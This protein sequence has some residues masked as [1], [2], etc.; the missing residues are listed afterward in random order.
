MALALT[1]RWLL[2]FRVSQPLAFGKGDDVKELADE[3]PLAEVESIQV[4]RLALGKTAL[5]TIQGRAFKL[6][7]VAGEDLQR[8]AE[9]FARAKTA[10]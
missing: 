7:V 8:L 9:E 10:A 1:G 4:K 3:A 2:V 6:E 5:V